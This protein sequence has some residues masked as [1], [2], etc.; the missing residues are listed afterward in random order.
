M[1]VY[2][3]VSRKGCSRLFELFVRI[4]C[5]EDEKPAIAQL[6]PPTADDQVRV[7]LMLVLLPPQN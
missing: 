1:I 3:H 2:L 5:M 6:Y 7:I 4:E